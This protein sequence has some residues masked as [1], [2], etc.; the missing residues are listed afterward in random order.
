MKRV[1]FSSRRGGR[2][3]RPTVEPLEARAL[4]SGLVTV[5]VTPGD[6]TN[7]FSPLRALGAGV[8]GTPSGTTDQIYTPSNIAKMLQAGH[9]PLT[10][11]LFTELTGTSWH[12]NPQGT[13]SDGA[14][15]RGYWTGDAHS[16][17]DIHL[18]YGYRLPQRGNTHDQGDN[19]PED[20]SQ[21]DDGDPTT[22]WK[23][24][25]YLTSAFTGE[26]DA[27]HPQWVVVDLGSS[28]G[29]D[30]VHLT[31]SNP[32]AVSYQVQYWTGDDAI[33]DPANGTWQDFP[34]G[35]VTGGTGG[36]VVLR[37][38]GTPI[39]V[40]FVRVLMTAS[41]GTADTHGGGDLRNRVG[42]ALAEIGVG[43]VPTGGGFTDLVVHV[44]DP[45]V[46]TVIY[47]SSTDPWSSAGR[48]ADGPDYS[49]QPGLD[50]VLGGGLTRGLPATLPAAMLYGTPDD[51]AA[52]ITYL[53]GRGYPIARVELGEEPDGQYVLPED[54]AALY[55]QW[56][57][58]LHAVDPNLALGGPVFSADQ[59]VSAWPDAQG[60]T[61]WLRRFL[62]YLSAHGAL[63][64]LSF[65]SFEHYPFDPCDTS[66]AR[67]RDE[68][69]YITNSLATWHND[70]LPAGVPVYVTEYN[71][72]Y[73]FSPAAVMP[74]GALWQAAFLGTFLTDGGS[75]AFFYQYEPTPLG[76]NA[77]CGG[78]GTFSMFITD[79]T[80]TAK[81]KG[82][83]FWSSQ[84]INT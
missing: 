42:Y 72:S 45:N 32:Y 61:S 60:D 13:W 28:Q 50:L 79:N 56:A 77:E 18:S 15:Q 39:S 16:S 9:G 34:Q 81:H 66:Y 65:M 80:Y 36:D 6:A 63:G 17:G 30:A 52:E 82:A 62:N 38:A 46:Q 78:W 24:N 7:H 1:L 25:P 75:G 37:V 74:V 58:A 51:A 14:N 83:E 76:Q 5:D 73:D 40:R 12:W 23:S 20:Y 57:N 2:S 22:Y 69:G 33:N 10:Y 68:P 27:L 67:V 48:I 21:I 53:E 64:E 3:A 26:P 4:P 84:V 44:P 47:V 49:E 41:S 31:W 19:A 71:Y 8:D 11:R 55:L 70:G 59:E 54:Y 35:T 43:T 29:V